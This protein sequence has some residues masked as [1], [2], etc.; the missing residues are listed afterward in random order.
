M[1]ASLVLLIGRCRVQLKHMNI[2]GGDAYFQPYLEN[3][4]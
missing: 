2:V 1:S 3:F 4:V